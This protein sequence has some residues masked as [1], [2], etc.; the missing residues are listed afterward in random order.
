[1]ALFP[2]LNTF[3][4][5][6]TALCQ[7]YTRRGRFRDNANLR[8]FGMNGVEAFVA[9]VDVNGDELRR[10]TRMNRC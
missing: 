2:F 3:I 4:S 1:M 7:L 8:N 5:V 6:L 9:E 10:S